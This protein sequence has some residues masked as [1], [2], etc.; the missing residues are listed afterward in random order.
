[1]THMID[2]LYKKTVKYSPKI[3]LD[4]MMITLKLRES[5]FEKINEAFQESHDLQTDVIRE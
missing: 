5:T 1:M 2:E 3:D 4:K